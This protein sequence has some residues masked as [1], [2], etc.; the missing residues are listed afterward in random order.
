[1]SLTATY[2]RNPVKVAVGVILLTMFGLIAI[3]RMPIQLIP[4]VSIPTLT[5]ETRW[6]GGSPQ[7]VER[8]IILEQEEQLQSVEGMTK[9]SSESMDSLGRITLELAVGTDMAEA[10]L[11]VNARLQQVREYPENADLPVISTSNSSDRPIGWFM[12]NQRLPTAQEIRAVQE[13]HPDLAVELDRIKNAHN[14]GLALFR[15]RK[16]AAKD[17]RAKELLPPDV[18]LTKRRRFMEDV[19]EARFERVPGVSNCNVVGGREEEMQVIVDPEQLAARQLTI[20]DV[21]QALRLH[22]RDT[23]AGDFWEG[24]RRYVVRTLGQFRSPEQVKSVIISRREGKPVYVSDV[25]TVELGYKKPSGIIRRFGTSVVGCNVLRQTGTNVLEVMDGLRDA[26]RE[27]NEGVLRPQG[28]ELTQVYDETEYIDSAVG[29]VSENIWEGA[30]LTVLVLLIFLRS[31][32]STLIIFL[33]IAVSIVGMFLMMYLMG[34][35]LNVPSLAGIAFAV[36]MLVDNFIV[37]LENI[38][39]RRQEG[40]SAVD[41]IVNGTGEVGGAVLSSTLTNLAV[42]VPVLFVQDQAGQLFR[43]IALATSSALGLSLLVALIMVPTAAGLFFRSMERANVPAETSYQGNGQ[44]RRRGILGRLSLRERFHR[45]TGFITRPLDWFGGKFVAGVVGLNAWVQRGI[46]RQVAVVVL[47]MGASIYISYLLLPKT[48]YLPGG[49]RNLIIGIMLPPPGYNLEQL[50]EIGEELEASL[51]PYWNIDPDS[52]EAASAPYPVVGDFFYVASGRML[53]MG[54]RSHDPLRAPELVPMMREAGMRVPGMFMVAKQTSLFEQ[55][56]IA[57]RTVDVEITGPDLNKLVALGGQVIGRVQQVVPGA[58]AIPKPSL[59]LSSPEVHV[60]PKWDQAADLGVNATDLG[61]TV[62]ALVDGAYATDYYLGGDKIDLTIIGKEKFASRTQD[63]KVLSIATPT[64][65]LVPLEA[66]AEVRLASGPEQINRRERQRAITIEVSPPLE[67]ALEDAL[68]R[69]RAEI[70][71]PLQ[72]SGQLEGGY[73]INLSGTADKLRTTWNALRWN[74]VLAVV[75]AYLLMAALFESWLYPFVI[76]MSVP[77]GAVGGFAGLWLLNQYTLQ[78]LDVLTMLGFVILVG[79]VVNNPIL[80]VEQA[81]VHI[82]QDG[83]H[84]RQAVLESVRTRIRP[85][86]MTALIGF[87]GLLPLVISP[88]AGSELYRG[89]GSVLLGGLAVSTIFT[90]VFAPTLFTLTLQ[91]REGLHRMLGF[92]TA[93]TIEPRPTAVAVNGAPGAD[94]KPEAAEVAARN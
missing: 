58:Q 24:K 11:K 48:E 72:E 35:T 15:L 42:F 28:L 36:G 16:L 51:E 66:V 3:K 4:E 5:I 91:A 47:L 53:F 55:G 62:D 46:I 30:L 59:D 18:D 67:M 71:Q 29:L 89:L 23:S 26:T 83:M 54:I 90:L 10:L 21:R 93:A 22:N 52:P 69:I 73:F 31:I 92:P 39:R 79:T 49:N 34:R 64:G 81:L 1:M 12:M 88:G 76:I 40:E 8:E 84:Y 80:I 85:I 60:R 68:D 20:Q 94:G 14:P 32:R 43:D 17:A 57:G 75:I 78:T 44:P 70:I 86:F 27:L 37:V 61:Y 7:E 82:R 9:M 63:L 87:F 45:L 56:L 25:A 19:V 77:L 74:L 50:K 41:A 2:I 6:P 33:A 65:E 38:Y 13:K